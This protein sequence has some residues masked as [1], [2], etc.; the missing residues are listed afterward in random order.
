VAQTLKKL[1]IHKLNDFWIFLF[2]LWLHR[3]GQIW[4]SVGKKV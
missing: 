2:I 4:D 3:L 1:K